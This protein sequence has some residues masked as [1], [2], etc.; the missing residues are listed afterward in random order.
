MEGLGVSSGWQ[1]AKYLVPCQVHQEK[2][3]RDGMWDSILA[4]LIRDAMSHMMVCEVVSSPM[5][6]IYWW[7]FQSYSG[8]PNGLCL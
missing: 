7:N 6:M 4:T 8:K 1:E 3:R 2:A 5:I